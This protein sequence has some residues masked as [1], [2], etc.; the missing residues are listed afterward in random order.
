M[1]KVI[2]TTHNANK[3]AYLA[4]C[5]T[6]GHNVFV[7]FCFREFYINCFTACFG[8]RNHIGKIEIRVGSCN[9]ISVM[10]ID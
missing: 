4:Q 6:L 3:P 1:T 7:S 9:K 5:N 8:L 10:V 2:A